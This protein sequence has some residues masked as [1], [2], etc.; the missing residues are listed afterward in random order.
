MAVRNGESIPAGR[1]SN[2]FRYIGSVAVFVSILG[3]IRLRS[4][5]R[6]YL[7]GGVLM[8][9]S[10]FDVDVE[11]R[12]RTINRFDRLGSSS[13]RSTNEC[14]VIIVDLWNS[15]QFFPR[16]TEL[17]ISFYHDHFITILNEN[18]FIENGFGISIDSIICGVINLKS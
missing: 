16:S 13:I 7:P 17:A 2:L 1:Q 3:C 11:Q 6:S 14:Q 8:I 5:N 9:V 4:V 15:E 10:E 18:N 12:G